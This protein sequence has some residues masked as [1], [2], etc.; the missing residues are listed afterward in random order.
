MNIAKKI[1]FE[2]EPPE[3][4]AAQI[5]KPTLW[6]RILKFVSSH[7]LDLETFNRIEGVLQDAPREIA[8]VERM[9]L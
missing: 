4:V 7:D 6:K 1:Y 3:I 9:W 8:R 2:S 5:E